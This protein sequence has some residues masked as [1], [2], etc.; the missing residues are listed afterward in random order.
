VTLFQPGKCRNC[1][2]TGYSGRLAIYEVLPITASIES[3]I[4][5]KASSYEIM[6][7]A[8]SEGLI[9]LRQSGI[10]KMLAGLT[11]LDEVLRV[12]LDTE[13]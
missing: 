3:L 13:G 12:S 8:I 11:S 5:T 4:T 10:N 6:R 9:P 2:D 1:E 7:Q